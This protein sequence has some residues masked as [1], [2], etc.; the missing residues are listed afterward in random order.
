MTA[1]ASPLVEALVRR[2][3]ADG[4]LTVADYMAEALGHPE[5]GYYAT[6]D[7]FGAAGDFV[8]APEVSQMFGELVG[9][10]ALFNWM[11]TG[12]PV[13]FNFAELGPGRGTLLADA[14]RAARIRPAFLDAMR[15]HLVE[16][17]PTLRDRQQELLLPLTA[18][19]EPP[20]WHDA[21]SDL[22]DGP[23][24]LIANEF[25]DA[26]PVHQYERTPA[27]W[28]E[29]A[30]GFDA[31]T[32]RLHWQHV[33]A[34]AT[35]GLLDPGQRALPVGSIV[36]VA[37]AALIHAAEI[38]QR[39]VQHG[40]ATLIVDYGASVPTGVPTFQA[41]RRHLRHDPLDTPGEADLT[42]HIDFGAI[43]RAAG[44]TGARVWGPIPQRVLLER[45]GI[46]E[47]AVQLGEN[48]TAEQKADIE[49]ALVRLLDATQMGNLFKAMA[50]T[51]G[52]APPPGFA[53]D[54]HDMPSRP[55]RDIEP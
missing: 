3:R 43:A 26:L 33:P 24:F 4:P 32:G 55:K 6:R 30:V 42:A 39:I 14:L 9:L 45:L 50:I 25:F 48:A 35:L 38:G 7:P 46:R 15:L 52:D 12:G 8:T 41:V 36:E 18:G 17:S 21:L 44:E 2:I 53:A 13:P 5:H 51:A 23:L 29:R 31:T 37:P 27:G 49:A 34:G 11:A 10:W 47:R 16:T 28:R 1:A 40:G 22:P 20:E 19:L 54:E